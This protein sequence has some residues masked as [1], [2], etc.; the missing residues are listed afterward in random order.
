MLTSEVYSEYKIW[1][2]ENNVRPLTASKVRQHLATMLRSDGVTEE[3]KG[4]HKK[5]VGIRRIGRP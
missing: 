4:R 2:D 3:G 5:L 1:C